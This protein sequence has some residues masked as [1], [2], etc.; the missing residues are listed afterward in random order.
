MGKKEDLQHQLEEEGYA[1]A[2]ASAIAHLTLR[3]ER[4]R[5]G[6]IVI[7]RTD[8]EVVSDKMAARVLFYL[9]HCYEDSANEDWRVFIHEIKSKSG[10]HRHQGGLVLFVLDGKGA[11]SF[12]GQLVEWEKG[13]LILFPVKPGGI[14]HQHFDLSGS[15]KWMAFWYSPVM[16]AVA[17]QWQLTEE[18]EDWTEEGSEPRDEKELALSEEA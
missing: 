7:K 16:D 15:A 18:R 17:T 4:A 6:K 9:D 12:D 8:R 5:N 13:D 1:P 14:D 11:T 10:K 3:R 2:H